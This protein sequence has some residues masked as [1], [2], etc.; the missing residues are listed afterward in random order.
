M[1]YSGLAALCTG[2]YYCL[3]F[4]IHTGIFLEKDFKYQNAHNN[5]FGGPF[6]PIMGAFSLYCVNYLTF[7]GREWPL[8]VGFNGPFQILGG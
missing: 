4:H 7:S 3:L 8:G 2:P 6:L 1:V 5:E